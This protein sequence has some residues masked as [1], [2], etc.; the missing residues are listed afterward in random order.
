MRSKFASVL[1]LVWLVSPS[2]A[3]G[4]KDAPVFEV[5]ATKFL[6]GT[7]VDITVLHSEVRGAQ[8]ACYAAFKEMERVESVLSA[9]KPDSEISRINSAAGRHPV[10]V[11]AET[12][13]IL[14]RAVS[15]SSRLEGRFDVT[16]GPVSELWGFNGDR[17]VALPQ[18]ERLQALLKLVDFRNLTLSE[19]DSTA[20]L[21]VKGMRLDLGGI[22]KGYAI[23]RAAT[24]LRAHG[25]QDFLI[26]A[27]GDIYASGTKPEG[28]KWRVGVQHPRRPRALL[29]TLEVSDMAV[30]T[31]G[32][33]E[34][35]VEIDGVR[36]H[37]ILD[38]ETG[39]PATQCQSVT[40]FAPTAEEADVW[41]TYC[42]IVGFEAY[43]HGP[44]R[45]THPALFVNASGRVRFTPELKKLYRLRLLP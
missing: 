9:H 16:I 28:Q 41:A 44:H 38:P 3:S 18:P 21:R 34:R 40:V 20:Y 1:L 31:S 2:L 4:R 29:A 15:Y 8:A 27:G 12:F 11:S 17:D 35:F 39:Y 23:D 26:N 6:L 14:A 7:K 36:Y 19:A 24:V 32:D 43:Q 22:A 5:S 30:A 13:A 42:F 37:H 25:L 45:S 10:K 33:Y